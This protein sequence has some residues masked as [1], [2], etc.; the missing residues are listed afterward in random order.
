VQTRAAEAEHRARERGAA[1]L[2]VT[3]DHGLL[4][5]F[6]RTIRMEELVADA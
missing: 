5:L 4:D 1:L 2:V 6:D 3:H